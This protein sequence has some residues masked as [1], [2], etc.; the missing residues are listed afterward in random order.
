MEDLQSIE[1]NQRLQ[2]YNGRIG[3][4]VFFA[5]IGFVFVFFDP[6]TAS[7]NQRQNEVGMQKA[8]IIAYQIYQIYNRHHSSS[9]LPAS[10]PN[11]SV[12]GQM[13][14]DPWGQAFRYRLVFDQKNNKRK[15]IVWSAGANAKVDTPNLE[16]EDQSN[17]EVIYAGD[18]FGF[19]LPML[20]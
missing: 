18:D 17:L 10:S 1:K 16:I 14:T 6:Q 7:D 4:I 19:E 3:S 11:E 2:G 12:Y 15:I 8:K 9:R 13:G 20:N 5:I